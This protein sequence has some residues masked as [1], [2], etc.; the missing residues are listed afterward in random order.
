MFAGT[1]R[2]LPKSV[3]TERGYFLVGSGQKARPEKIAK[4]KHSS[5]FQ[6]LVNYSRKK[7]YNIGPWSNSLFA[8]EVRCK[9]DR[10]SAIFFLLE[11][12]NLNWMT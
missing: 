2:S 7:S 6:K 1:A 3:S 10:T 9:E 11:F 4:Q 8:N 5:L 12:L